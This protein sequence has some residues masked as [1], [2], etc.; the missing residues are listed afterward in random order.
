MKNFVLK[1][2]HEKETNAR[3]I[4]KINISEILGKYIQDH[5]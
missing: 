5:V 1:I 4:I 2:L 3:D